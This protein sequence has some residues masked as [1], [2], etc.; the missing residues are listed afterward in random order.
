MPELRGRVVAVDLDYWSVK[1]LLEIP[2][3]GLEA[4]R[5]SVDAASLTS[6]A[7]EAAGSPQLMQSIRL[8]Q[9]SHLELNAF[10]DAELLRNPLLEREDGPEPSETADAPEGVEPSQE[11]NAY[12]DTVDHGDRIQSA[13][14]IASSFSAG[15]LVLR[16]GRLSSIVIV[17]SGTEASTRMIRPAG[18]WMT[19]AL[20]GLAG[21]LDT[22]T[23]LEPSP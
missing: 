5:F 13:D 14:A 21:C 12:E 9:L 23:T 4:L 16:T 22:P 18:A 7:R 17:A 2:R 10:V 20:A 3:M 11:L 8:L 15:H 19:L 6:F 1:D